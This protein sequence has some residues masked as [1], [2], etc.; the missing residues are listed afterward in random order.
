MQLFARAENQ[1]T[2]AS[3]AEKGKDYTCPECGSIVRLRKGSYRIAH[4]FHRTKAT[5]HQSQKG[6]IH[7]HLQ[8]LLKNLLIEEEA[9]LE[10]PFPHI[11]RIADVF[12]AK[13]Q[14]VF[15]IQ[16]SPMS[17]EEAQ[18][19]CHDYE[20]QGITL[21]W[22]LHEDTFNQYRVGRTEQFLRTK[23]CYYTNMDKH[24]RGEVYDQFEKLEEGRRGQRSVKK[25]V[26]LTQWFSLPPLPA[27]APAWLEKRLLGGS[28]YHKGD[29]ID[30]ALHHQIPGGW[31][32]QEKKRIT[33]PLPLLKNI[34]LA[35]LHKLLEK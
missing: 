31:Q 1:L 26:D 27:E 28:C 19:R 24:G 10:Y 13:T 35:Y 9:L 33:N 34:Y 7:L 14:K 6:V 15:E 4:F 17:L 18:S 12:C 32:V 20:S 16:Y 21:I 3:S 2:P 30:L 8:Y 5:C 25:K 11:G 23:T 22:I 29:L